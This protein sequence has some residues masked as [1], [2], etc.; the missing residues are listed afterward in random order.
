MIVLF[1]EGEG[2]GGDEGP[3]WNEC[4]VY[5]NMKVEHAQFFVNN[6]QRVN[7]VIKEEKESVYK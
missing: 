6:K 4:V 5:K 3:I 7:F 1:I 2:E